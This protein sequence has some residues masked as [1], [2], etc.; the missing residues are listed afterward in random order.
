MT[1]SSFISLRIARKFRKKSPSKNKKD[2]DAM[3]AG[4][5]S[6]GP[7]SSKSLDINIQTIK[8]VDI[9]QLSDIPGVI[10]LNN[11][12]NT[13]F[14]NSVLQCLSNTEHI[15]QYFLLGNYKY[16]LKCS[17]KD[18]S[19]KKT[20]KGEITEQVAA[21]IISLWTNCYHKSMTSNLKELM[22][23]HSSQYKGSYQH[24]SL[25][26]LLWLFDKMHEDISIMSS[27]QFPTHKRQS[28][29][30][31]FKS[32]TTIK[33]DENSCS[34]IEKFFRGY[35]K[36]T[37]TCPKCG[38]I[39]ETD[40]SFLS[41]SLPLKHRMT[42]P[43]YVNVSFLPHKRSSFRKQPTGKT[44]LLGFSMLKDS[45]TFEDI[46][47][48][49][50]QKCNVHSRLLAF[51][52]L[53]YDGFYQSF[54][55]ND[56]MSSI[57]VPNPHTNGIHTSSTSSMSTLY[58]FEL[59][60]LN[61]TSGTL[62]RNFKRASSKSSKS[63][64]AISQKP[65]SSIV[66]ILI[67]KYCDGN[68][69]GRFG[70]PLVCRISRDASLKELQN[71]IFAQ[72]RPYIKEDMKII[73]F[74]KVFQIKVVGGIPNREIIS[75]NSTSPLKLPTVD[76]ALENCPPGNP[77]H[78]KMVAEW[79]SNFLSFEKIP[80]EKIEVDESVVRVR[81]QH[82][83]PPYCTLQDCFDLLMK[84]EE[85]A[86]D[87]S[88]KCSS[89]NNKHANV[90]KLNFFNIP[91]VLVVHLLRFEVGTK[92]DNVVDFPITGLDM[93]S[94][95]QKE[96][97]SHEPSSTKKDF[98]DQVYDLYGVVNHY[99]SFNSGHYNSACN[100]PLDGKWYLYDDNQVQPIDS[101]LFHKSSAYILFY[102]RR[103]Q[104][105]S[106]SAKVQPLTI[107]EE[108]WASQLPQLKEKFESHSL[109]N[110][111]KKH[112]S[113]YSSATLPSVKKNEQFLKENLETSVVH[114]NDNKEKTHVPIQN[115]D[116]YKTQ[117]SNI[118]RR[119]NTSN[120]IS[121]NKVGTTNTNQSSNKQTAENDN[122]GFESPNRPFV[123]GVS[124]R[125]GRNKREVSSSEIK[126]IA[127][128]YRSYRKISEKNRLTS[129]V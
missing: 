129:L 27:K 117:S 116:S 98:Q 25:E 10:G 39:S 64:Y 9:S 50:A 19:K 4:F 128:Q 15:L 99:G 110:T 8:G 81:S 122:G 22:S 56:S 41:I 119:R 112:K 94:R 118:S 100:N 20:G 107:T 69:A 120:R 68:K 124:L 7:K 16:D 45:S 126:N 104:K 51:V 73:S 75:N 53:R 108:H 46:R 44:T 33:T 57:P 125:Y 115:N 113:K 101:N 58:A 40:E 21:I 52:D 31:K 24:D 63:D 5:N 87:N 61:I 11:H 93:T 1:F 13:C 80:D 79:K 70:R 90:K 105:L 123:R 23:K 42:R 32:M 62:P 78:L 83:Q 95:I 43:V 14:V 26:F 97:K 35:T 29:R 65:S 76:H 114:T 84:E 106:S 103:K 59:P 30:K 3:E 109:S 36:S 89:C 60:K 86:D 55:D 12:G 17:K 91:D 85:L 96:I 121:W 102:R 82:S 74:E 28:M 71:L 34:F 6:S 18:K 111:K 72:F 48:A 49:V 38:K 66:V 77:P 47:C 54:G 127:K 88:W 67:N 92:L 2:L 37:L